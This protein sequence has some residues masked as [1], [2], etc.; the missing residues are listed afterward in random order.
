MQQNWVKQGLLIK[1]NPQ[2]KWMSNYIGP[3]FAISRN[4]RYI[5]IYFSSRDKY[6]ISTIGKFSFDTKLEKKSKFRKILTVSNSRSFDKHGVS[7]PL[8]YNYRKKK[9]LF[10][11]GWKKNTKYKF[12]NTL[13]FAIKKKE[14]FY[15]FKKIFNKKNSLYGSGSCYILKNNNK[16][17]LWFTSFIKKNEKKK[18]NTHYKYLI[19]L[20]TSHNL[21][22][23]RTISKPCINFL[24]ENEV[25]ISKPTV[26][27]KNNNFHM[28]YCYRGKKYKIGYAISKNGKDWIRKDNLVKFIG[29]NLNWD[30]NEK[31]YPSVIKHDKKFYMFYSGNNYGKDGVGYAILGNK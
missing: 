18:N 13:A 29:K 10:Y 30:K 22:K 7:Y 28:W 12:E 11:V 26:I 24:S 20:A 15:N 8:I 9:Y 31:C 4:N 5:D 23:W 1:K 17:F 25:A 14:I 16:H 3:C 27:Y 6:N 21:K 2:I 19:K